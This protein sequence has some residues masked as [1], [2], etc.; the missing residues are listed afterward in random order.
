MDF[1]DITHQLASRLRELRTACG[2]SLEV[3]AER[4]QV[5]R[6]NI[7]L[8]ER[9]ESSP[10]AVVLDKLANALGVTLPALFDE[11]V[12][13]AATQPSPLALVAEQSVWTDPASGYVRRQLSPALPSPIQLVEV[14]FP[15]GQRVAYESSNRDSMVYQQVW[16]IEG[17]M[18][19]TVNGECRRLHAGD[20]LA[21]KLDSPIVY[22]NPTTEAAH[23][24]V[25]LATLSF[26]AVR[27]A[28]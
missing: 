28:R 1:M 4:S 23:Y 21:M 14:H 7:S 13:D 6:S 8:I 24:L 27:G 18:E 25:S 22:V 12:S 20:C 9:G 11:R 2:F 10:T 16:L 5:S 26:V 17:S 3:L 15:A 19:I